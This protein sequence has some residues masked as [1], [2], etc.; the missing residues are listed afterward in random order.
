M[1][2]R[3]SPELLQSALTGDL[4]P[5]REELLQRHL[6]ECETCSQALERMAGD[7]KLW[8][9]AAAMF[10]ANDPA[11]NL[12]G[13]I[14]GA[15]R[16]SE[17]EWSDIDFSVEHLEPSDEPGVL[18]RLGGYDVLEIIG[19]GGMGVV[20]KGYDPELSRLRGHQGPLAATG[21]QLAG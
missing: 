5:E 19:R 14:G 18:G 21:A 11:C 4:P 3:C 6:E 7:A 8:H 9:E 12:D 20:L 2:T 13:A 1:A 10:A 17:A 15:S 16:T